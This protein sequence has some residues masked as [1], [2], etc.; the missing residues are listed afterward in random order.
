MRAGVACHCP[1]RLPPPGLGGR[2]MA[3]NYRLGAGREG[4][5]RRGIVTSTSILYHTNILYRKYRTQYVVFYF[6][7]A[8]IF[9][10]FQYLSGYS[11]VFPRRPHPGQ[12]YLLQ[13]YPPICRLS[14]HLSFSPHFEQIIGPPCRQMGH[15]YHFPVPLQAVRE[16]TSTTRHQHLPS[17]GIHR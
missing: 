3:R 13:R 5:W 17:P 4:R 16:G 1:G 9:S 12:T 10:D 11:L 14:M 2:R 15:S 7:F 6:F 8:W